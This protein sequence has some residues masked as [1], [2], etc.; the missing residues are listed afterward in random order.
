MVRVLWDA[1]LLPITIRNRLMS[2]LLIRAILILLRLHVPIDYRA[3]VHR[4]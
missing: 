2:Y 1:R 4:S 3:K